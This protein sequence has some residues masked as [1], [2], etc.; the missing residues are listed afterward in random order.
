[1]NKKILIVTTNYSGDICNGENCIKETGVNLEEFAVP[2]LIFKAT[3]IFVECASLEG[4]LSPIDEDSMSCSNPMEWDDCIK[5]LRETKKLS[6][7]K[8]DDFD[9]I[10]FPGG[11]GTMFDIAKS[12]EITKA[13]EYFYNSSKIIAA[14]CHGVSALVN[15]KDKKDNPIVKN[16]TLTSFTDKEEYII[17]YDSAVPFLLQEK[18]TNLGANFIE[19]KPWSEHVEVDRNFITGQ[20]NKSATLIAEKIIEALENK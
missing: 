16:I 9:C 2:Y 10:Y 3:G 19:E 13:V 1:M 18:L 6:N 8:L 4:G 14:I 17:K 11:H 15:A 20:N 12:E 5:I 7:I